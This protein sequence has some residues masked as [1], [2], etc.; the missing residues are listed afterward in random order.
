MYDY[1]TTDYYFNIFK[2]PKSIP[3]EDVEYYL[4]KSIISLDNAY[5]RE[6]SRYTNAI[7]FNGLSE[8]EQ[9]LILNSTCEYANFLYDNQDTLYPTAESYSIGDIKVSNSGG[10]LLPTRN[11][12]KVTSEIDAAFHN[13]RFC[14]RAIGSIQW[15]VL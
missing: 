14:N 10:A 15:R 3:N 4:E 7:G 5:N 2:G 11:G 1:I 9:Y 6:I 12:I 8:Y 13:S